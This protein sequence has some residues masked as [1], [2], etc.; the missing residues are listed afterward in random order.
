MIWT[1]TL[2]V[3]NSCRCC[4]HLGLWQQGLKLCHVAKTFRS[5]AAQPEPFT[6]HTGRVEMHLAVSLFIPP[7]HSQDLEF[8][9]PI[10]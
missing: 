7:P 4:S 5:S 9:N 3:T 1:N 2:F 8:R 10:E 6:N